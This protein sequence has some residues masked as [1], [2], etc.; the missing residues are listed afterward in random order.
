MFPS[1]SDESQNRKT[2][3][4][5]ALICTHILDKLELRYQQNNAKQ[6]HVSSDVI[7]IKSINCIKMPNYL[8][9]CFNYQ[10]L[11]VT[12]SSFSIL[13]EFLTHVGS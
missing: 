2:V 4:L 11:V 13:Q 8:K 1:G 6:E 10:R 12:C 7:Q 9:C 3:C 5:F